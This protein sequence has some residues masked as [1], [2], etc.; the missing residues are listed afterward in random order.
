MFKWSYVY[1]RKIPQNFIK[2]CLL[3]GLKSIELV[4]SDTMESY[5]CEFH[6]SERKYYVEKFIR[7]DWY[8]FSK[9]MGLEKGDI[10]AFSI[11]HPPTRRLVVRVL[12]HWKLFSFSGKLEVDGMKWLQVVQRRLLIV[13]SIL[14][15]W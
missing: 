12:N 15:T 6:T 4:D 13:S 10:V 11:R 7:R 14:L 3:T 1:L 2:T 9:N 5:D 8:V